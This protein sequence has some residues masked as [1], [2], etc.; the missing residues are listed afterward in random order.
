MTT[1]CARNAWLVA[2]TIVLALATPCFDGNTLYAQTVA[3]ALSQSPPPQPSGAPV[4][5]GDDTLFVIYDK[6]GPFTPEERARA[7]AERL[8]QLAKD[9]FTRIYPVTAIERDSTSELVYGDMVVMTVTDRD[10]QPTGKTRSEATN[11][12]AQKV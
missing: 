6:I 9:P 1:S 4:V 2:A 11:A 7:F 5:F 10:A 3:P 8:A 12:Y